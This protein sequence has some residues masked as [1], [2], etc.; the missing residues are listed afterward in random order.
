MATT[1]PPAALDMNV[2]FTFKLLSAPKARLLHIKQTKVK[3]YLFD[4]ELMA[5]K[6]LM[7]LGFLGGFGEKNSSL[8][9]GMVGIKK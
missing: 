5:P 7:R 2:P 9:M 6:D 4:F 3:G 1:A 8:G